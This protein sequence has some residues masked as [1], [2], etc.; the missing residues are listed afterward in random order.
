MTVLNP[1][2]TREVGISL[3]GNIVYTISY[4]HSD[5]AN[6]VWT[7]TI[8]ADQAEPYVPEYK[9][10]ERKLLI[11][12]NGSTY[13]LASLLPKMWTIQTDKKGSGEG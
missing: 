2:A 7:L 13:P 10:G 12:W 8:P 3:E 6:P 9:D 4:Y 1:D 5:K 11:T